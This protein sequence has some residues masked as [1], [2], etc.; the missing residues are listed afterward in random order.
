[1]QLESAKLLRDILDAAD[2]IGHYAHGKAREQFLADQLTRDAVNWNFSIV[3]EA[4]AQ[5]RKLDAATA[6]G[7]TD[8]QRIIAFR[9]QLIHG[10][11]VIKNEITWDIIEQKLPRLRGEVRELL[12]QS[13]GRA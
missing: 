4:L 9:N 11:G 6:A 2:R 7:I 12:G 10:Y 8:W 1:M 3:G 5:L 13:D